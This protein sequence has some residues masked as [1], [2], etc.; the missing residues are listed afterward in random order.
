MRAVVFD[1][2]GVLVD[3]EPLSERAWATVLGRYGYTPDDGDF[4][5]TRGTT[6]ADTTAYFLRQVEVAPGEPDLLNQVDG[7]RRTLLRAELESFPDAVDSVRALAAEGVPLAVASSS[8]RR[9]LDLKLAKFDLARYFDVIVAGDEVVGGNLLPICSWRPPGS[10]V[11]TLPPALPSTTPRSAPML[12]SPQACG[13]CS[14]RET[15]RSQGDTRLCPRWNR[16]SSCI[17]WGSASHP[18]HRGIGCGVDESGT[19]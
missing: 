3:S 2:D 1:C 10:W 6:S 19:L 14:S 11:S 8:S 5:A 12:P 18:T 15:V 17:G 4:L 9:N 7:V 13:R 16:S